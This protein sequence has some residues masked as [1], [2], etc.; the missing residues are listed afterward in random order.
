MEFKF[1]VDS[2]GNPIIKVRHH[3]K[4]S[5][6]ESKMFAVFIKK[7]QKNGLTLSNPSSAGEAGDPD[8]HENYII[9]CV[10]DEE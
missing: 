2:E 4:R 10:R 6:L 3:D 9:K 1:T 5:D 7:A 8:S